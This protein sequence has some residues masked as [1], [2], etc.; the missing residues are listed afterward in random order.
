[1][2]AEELVQQLHHY[3]DYLFKDAGFEVVFIDPM[4]GQPHSVTVG[5]ES[6]TCRLLFAEE[7][8]VVT[9]LIGL[10]SAPFTEILPRNGQRLWLNLETVTD[11]I[12]QNAIN[13]FEFQAQ[14]SVEEQLSYYTQKIRPHYKQILTMF[15]DPMALKAWY[16]RFDEYETEQFHQQA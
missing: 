4:I 9:P 15:Q 3:F 2:N 11:F 1:M 10:S 13:W 16:A 6:P 7:Q 5:L 8:G 14:P 12:E